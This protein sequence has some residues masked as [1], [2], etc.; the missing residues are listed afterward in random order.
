MYTSFSIENFRLF[1]ELTVEP[2]ARVNLI[3]GDNNVGKTALLEALWLHSGPNVPEL[4][5][6]IS[7][8]RGIPGSDPRRWLH[9]IFYDFDPERKI[10]FSA[11]G[12]WG[13]GARTLKVMSRTAETSVTTFPSVDSPLAPQLGSQESDFLSMSASEIV[14]DYT[15]EHEGNFVSSGR[16]ARTEMPS[17]PLLP[18]LPFFAG[19]AMIAHQAPMPKRPSNVFISARLRRGPEDDVARFGEVELAGFS[20]RIED[21]L[22]QVAPEIK[23]LTTISAAPTPM[24]Y[25]DIGLSRPVPMAFLGDGVGR[26]LSMALAFHQ[27]R[28]G[29]VLIDEIENGL[30]YSKLQGVWK[31][32]DL[33][34]REFNVQVF[35]TTHSYECIV[36]ANN[37]FTDTESDELHLHRL[38]RRGGRVKAV[39]YDK[40]SLDTNIEYFWELR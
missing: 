2:L 17:V 5:Q 33:L 12:D 30:H 25:A 31:H 14:F 37:A 11:Q 27:A 13:K 34:S 23:R 4:A 29:R 19:E 39:S 40:E 7:G 3:V 36:A 8:F 32:V 9:D 6:R 22:R 15:D 18:N 35:A 24:I 1:E 16:L 26:L 38:Y 10:S 28:G 20:S 21:C